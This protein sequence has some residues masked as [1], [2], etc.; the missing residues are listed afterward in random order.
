[1][2]YRSL[3][4]AVTL[5][6][7]TLFCPAQTGGFGPPPQF[8][9]PHGDGAFH[10][11]GSVTGT[12]R[13]MSGKAMKDVQV[14]L[15][16]LSH[17][18]VMNSAFT[19]SSGEFQFNN[20]PKGTYEVVASVGVHQAQDRVEVS[21]WNASTNLRMPVSDAP[22]DGAGTN[23]ISV[24]QYKVPEKAREELARARDATA[25]MKF[26]EA[27]KHVSKALEIYPHFADAL[28]LQAILKL[29]AK[30]PDGAI[31]DLQN[32][33]Q[34]DGN[35]G[36]AYVVLG[37]AY[38]SQG[39]YDLAVQ[40]LQRGQTLAPDSWQAYFEMARAYLGKEDYRAAL[41]QVDKAQTLMNSDFAP[42]RLARAEALF[43]LKQYS[44]S[45]AELQQ[46]LNKDPSGPNSQQAQ[47]MLAKA[48]E[49]EGT[50]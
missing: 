46:F 26:D 49:L 42:L 32:A 29:S 38:N 2:V 44:D 4:L 39:K 22:E 37:A 45:V 15:L 17:G 24:A 35:Y 50:R 14:Q 12:V 20:V 21:A 16:E 31:A 34:C 18:S 30:E 13:T 27:Q 6:T 23:T 28:T 7:L 8:Q 36:L 47:Q 43:G 11:M 33:I 19:N 25:K 48:R 10:E 1:M 9:P 5:L 41:Q 3:Q 40:P